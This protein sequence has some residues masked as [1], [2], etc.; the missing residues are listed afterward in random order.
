[1]KFSTVL[2]ALSKSAESLLPPAH[3]TCH[4]GSD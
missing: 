3:A 1:M 4:L 2:F